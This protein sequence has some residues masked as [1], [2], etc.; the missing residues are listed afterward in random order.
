V[1][2][3][4]DRASFST[5]HAT[6]ELVIESMISPLRYQF[7]AVGGVPIEGGWFYEFVFHGHSLNLHRSPFCLRAQEEIK[8]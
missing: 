8:A 7:M 2:V 1:S 6:P 3:V 4:A 5:S